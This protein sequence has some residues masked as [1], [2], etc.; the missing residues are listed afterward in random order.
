MNQTVKLFR[1]LMSKTNVQKCKFM[2]KS[3]AQ[4]DIHVASPSGLC[5]LANETGYII[6][7]MENIQGGWPSKKVIS[8]RK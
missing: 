1:S 2:S 7:H 6:C 8:T 5:V 4:C 3:F